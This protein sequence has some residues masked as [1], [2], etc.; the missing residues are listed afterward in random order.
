MTMEFAVL[1][2]HTT[3]KL[4][5]SLSKF[6]ITTRAVLAN[7]TKIYIRKIIISH[8][9]SQKGFIKSWAL[10]DLQRS[11]LQIVIKECSE[12]CK[13]YHPTYLYRDLDFNVIIENKKKIVNS[14]ALVNTCPVMGK[15]RVK[16]NKT[17]RCSY[18][19]RVILWLRTKFKHNLFDW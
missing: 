14:I 19:C 12:G 3:P 5:V 18:R 10:T 1:A 6:L 16:I 2:S 4:L 9:H 11:V 13:I 7:N 17:N 15:S 8:L